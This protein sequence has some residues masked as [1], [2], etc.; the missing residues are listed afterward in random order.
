MFGWPHSDIE[1][2]C[3]YLAKMGWAGVKVY[4]A[5]EQVMSLQPFNNIL[6][7]WYFH[8]QPVSYRFEGRMGNHDDLRTM[9]YSCRKYGVRIYA[10]AVNNHMVGSGNDGNPDHRNSAGSCTYWPNKNTSAAEKS[11]FYTQGFAYTYNPHTDQNALQEFPSVPYGPLDFHC[12]RPLNSWTDPLQLNAGWLSGLVDINTERDN[13]RERIADYWTSLMSIGHS[14]FR[15]DAAKHICPDDTVAIF[16]KFRRNMGGTLPSEFIAWLEIL[17]G[18]E[19]SMLMCNENSGYNYGKYLENKLY[20]AGFSSTEVAQIKIWNSGYPKEPDADCNSISNVRNAVQNDDH[21]QQ[22]PGSSSR[23]MGSYGSVLVKDKDV[24]SHRGFE[25]QLFNAPRGA[26]DNDNDYPVRILLSSWYFPNDNAFGIPDGLSDCNLCQITCTG[27][28]TVP[29][30]PAFSSTSCGYDTPLYTRTHRDK[31]VILAMR[32]WMHL[33]TN[34][35]N[36]QLGLPDN[37][38]AY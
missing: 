36:A 7:P 30:A 38:V 34:V 27:C 31:G 17:L 12:E 4:P 13:V 24:G 26:T 18:G 15:V 33:P 3:Q 2:E 5:M 22:M 1:K 23:D 28:L 35:S 10:D 32:Q 9:I 16:S 19:A 25:K 8:Y 20:A 11:P 6:N 29:Y 14:G 21:D 37:C